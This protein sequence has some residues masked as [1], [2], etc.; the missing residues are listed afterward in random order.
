MKK[1]FFLIFFLFLAFGVLVVQ[2]LPQDTLFLP[3]K[4]ETASKRGAEWLGQYNEPYNDPGIV[5]IVKKINDTYCHSSDVDEFVQTRFAEF[6]N[7]PV[8][9]YYRVLIDGNTDVAVDY[10]ILTGREKFF[11]DIIL[12]PLYCQKQPIPEATLKKIFESE[13]LAGYDLTHHFL[14]LQL[15]KENQC[16]GEQKI[17]TAMDE[18]AQYM[19]TEQVVS[20]FSDLFAERIAFLQ[21]GG[22]E[23]S[24]KDQWI[25]TIIENQSP[26]GAWKDPNYFEKIDNPHTTALAVWALVQYTQQC[27]F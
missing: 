17:K 1:F 2:T 21:Y 10:S 3:K 20:S 19:R 8:Q 15:M 13:N 18:A 4:A 9:K 5:W 14:S 24:I 6:E 25:Q 11:D 12:P 23:D 16:L 22:Y 26:S 7:D 27:P